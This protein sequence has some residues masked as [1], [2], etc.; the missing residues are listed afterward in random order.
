MKDM[1][2]VYAH[3]QLYNALFGGLGGSRL[4]FRVLTPGEKSR[5]SGLIK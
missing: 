3:T 4:F 5:S 1:Y 2:I